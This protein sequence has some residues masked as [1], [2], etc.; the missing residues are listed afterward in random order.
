MALRM[1]RLAS[2]TGIAKAMLA[3]EGGA[4]S[5]DEKSAICFRAASLLMLRQQRERQRQSPPV[6]IDWKH[7]MDQDLAISS[8]C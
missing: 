7:S 2:T 1:S 6:R 8:V 5:E 3:K 4:G